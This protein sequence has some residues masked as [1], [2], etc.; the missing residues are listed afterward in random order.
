MRSTGRPSHGPLPENVE[1]EVRDR[2]T[3]I[4]A[5]VGNDSEPVEQP[6][7]P[8]EFLDGLVHRRQHDTVRGSRFEE[9][10]HMVDRDDQEMDRGLGIDIVKR[11]HL[12]ITMDDLGGDG[13]L[14][15]FAKEAII[16]IFTM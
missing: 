15:N 12:I 14:D 9:A 1:V 13:A 8:G 16:H 2:L 6:R 3:T 11:H 5:T 4:A 10:G 7:F